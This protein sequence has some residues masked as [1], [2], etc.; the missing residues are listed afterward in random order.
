MKRYY[1]LFNKNTEQPYDAKSSRKNAAVDFSFVEVRN[2]K[3]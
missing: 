3:K 2:P 1:D